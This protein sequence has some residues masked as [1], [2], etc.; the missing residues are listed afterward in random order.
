MVPKVKPRIKRERGKWFCFSKLAYGYGKS[1]GE[2]W[3]NMQRMRLRI[4]LSLL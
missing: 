2:A 4:G 1:I 3:K